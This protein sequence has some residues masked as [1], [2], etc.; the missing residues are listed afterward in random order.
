[1]PFPSLCRRSRLRSVIRLV[2]A[3][4]M[5]PVVATACGHP[6]R[7]VATAPATGSATPS[8]T[9]T[10]D[11]GVGFATLM[12]KL[13]PLDAAQAAAV[14]SADASDGYRQTLLAAIG[15]ELEP[16]QRQAAQLA[17]TPI[18]RE[19][20]L[21]TRLELAGPGR[22]D[23]QVWVMVVAG[24]A[25]VADNAEATFDTV[26]VAMVFE[27]GGWRLDGT[28]ETTGPTPEVRAAPSD[29]DTLT[30]RLAGFGDWRPST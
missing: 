15:T 3:A 29:V 2:A 7:K 17:G 28:S 6:G 27:R 30:S 1:V 16:L 22:A 13:F 19:S 24:Q 12:A 21:A 25:G 5:F 14:L 10:L 26:T 4:A 9:S 20:V 18:Y 23:L 8:L 11:A